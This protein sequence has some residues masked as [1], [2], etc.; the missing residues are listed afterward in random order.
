MAPLDPV[1]PVGVG[2]GV[3]VAVLDRADDHSAGVVGHDPAVR[4]VVL[5][6]DVDVLEARVRKVAR[7]VADA[8]R[9]C[10]LGRRERPLAW[11]VFAELP[12]E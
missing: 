2:K 8:G 4:R 12:R 3:K 1:I 6:L 10:K 7:S 5:K 11:R 9:W